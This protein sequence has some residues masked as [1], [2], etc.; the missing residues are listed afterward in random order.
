MITGYYLIYGFTIQK[1]D[2]PDYYARFIPPDWEEETATW[3]L[4]ECFARTLKTW[5]PPYQHLNILIVPHDI[6]N[7]TSNYRRR[8]ETWTN[9]PAAVIGVYRH[10]DSPNGLVDGTSMEAFEA[11]TRRW[12]DEEVREVERFHAEFGRGRPPE[13]FVVPNDCACCT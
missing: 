8:D 2:L 5:S 13:V 11:A 10:L 7:C 1:E 12:S 4:E 3:A 6:A 9:T